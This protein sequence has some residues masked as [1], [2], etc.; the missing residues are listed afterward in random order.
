MCDPSGLVARRQLP[1]LPLVVAPLVGVLLY[2]CLHG[3]APQ[4][5][6]SARFASVCDIDGHSHLRSATDGQLVVPHTK[7]KTI[8]VRGFHVSG[9]TFSE[10]L[11]TVPSRCAVTGI[12]FAERII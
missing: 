10:D 5:Y 11:P 8:V 1:P 12:D 6:L 2:K 4:A 7:M 9:P 3:V